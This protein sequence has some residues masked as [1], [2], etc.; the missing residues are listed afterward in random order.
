MMFPSKK[1]FTCIFTNKRPGNIVPEQKVGKDV[2][3][4]NFIWTPSSYSSA[5]S[6][7]TTIMD[8]STESHF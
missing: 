3:S 4:Y 5:F 6:M 8:I 1:L 2:K 7:A